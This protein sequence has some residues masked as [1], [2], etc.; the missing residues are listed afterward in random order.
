[1]PAYN[2][3]QP[4]NAPLK[5]FGN[6]LKTFRI[7]MLDS[8]TQHQIAQLLGMKEQAY[9]RLERGTAKPTEKVL[10]SLE[11]NFVVENIRASLREET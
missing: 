3:R 4:K 9:G 6:K 8:P 1:M 10:C 5:S 11:T 2:Q 7:A